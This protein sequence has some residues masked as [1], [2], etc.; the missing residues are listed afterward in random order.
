V[1]SGRKCTVVFSLSMSS[2]CSN[3]YLVLCL[4]PTD[5]Y[6]FVVPHFLHYP[7]KIVPLRYVIFCHL[8]ENFRIELANA[9]CVT[10][11]VKGS[12]VK[13]CVESLIGTSISDTTCQILEI[14]LPNLVRSHLKL[15]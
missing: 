14:N 11:A 12:L 6:I 7:L 9:F 10:I 13:T 1:P 5:F 2:S 8:G 3:L 15:Y 4:W